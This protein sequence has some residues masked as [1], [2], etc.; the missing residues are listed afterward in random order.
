MS[1]ILQSHITIDSLPQRPYLYR[2]LA[3][4]GYDDIIEQLNLGHTH[5]RMLLIEGYLLGNRI[6]KALALL[7]TTQINED[8]DFTIFNY[9]DSLEFY[10]Q[11]EKIWLS[12]GIDDTIYFK[13]LMDCM[14]IRNNNNVLTAS[15]IFNYAL[16]KADFN[17]MHLPSYHKVSGLLVQKSLLDF[18]GFIQIWER[19]PAKHKNV[20]I[21]GLECNEAKN[22]V[23]NITKF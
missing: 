22:I 12:S 14:S 7:Q 5:D 20:K 1:I 21:H 8:F 9:V 6:D 23:F 4:Y 15:K 16:S 10:Q 19:L 13:A 2:L 18:H 17:F 11:M 3:Q